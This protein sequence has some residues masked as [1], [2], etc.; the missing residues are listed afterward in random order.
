M[1]FHHQQLTWAPL[2]E[3]AVAGLEGA[4]LTVPLDHTR[5][6]GRTITLG[7]GR[8]RAGNPAARRGVL[9]VG[10]GDDLGNRGLVLLGQLAR[11]L[12]D[13]VRA[14]Y[15]LVGFDHRFMG[16][17]SPVVVG[18]EPEER[19]WVFHHPRDFE[20][21]VRFQAKVAAKVAEHAMDVL[22]YASSR[23][24]ARDMDVIRAVLG[25]ERISYLG[26]SYGT[27]LGAVYARMF[28]EHVDRVVLDSM[29][30]PDWVWRG[31]FTDFSPNGERALNRWAGWAARHHDRYGLGETGARVRAGYDRLLARAEGEPVEVSGF[32]FDRTLIR[33]VAVGML[34]SDLAYEHLADIVRAAV[35][36]GP[37]APSTL[38]YMA[39][40]F[41]QPKEESGTVAQLAILAGDWSWPRDPDLYERDMRAHGE[42][43]PFA[44]RAMAGI[45]ATAFW[46]VQPVEPPTPLDTGAPAPGMLLVAADQDMSTP[47]A[48]GVRMREVFAREAR[49]L[50]VA[51]TAHHRVFPFYRNAAVDEVV[52]GYLVDG[53]LPT[54]DL[55][56]PNLRARVAS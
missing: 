6:G 56:V 5:P 9:L 18:L 33:L 2:D 45:K 32:P 26:Y 1:D 19:L 54:A 46:P 21:E 7:L 48:A 44:G 31:L 20:H 8:L 55:T 17:S 11:A 29:C 30:S 36:G 24:I 16:A 23:N 39:P 43:W 50:T 13:E 47:H 37:F 10:P 35:H 4:T 53:V 28:P 38:E 27:Y 12:P 42:R 49:L 34:N 25:E 41:A 22:P 3:P 52:T 51:D 14:C 40:M 15:D